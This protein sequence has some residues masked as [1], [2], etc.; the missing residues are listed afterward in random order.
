[1]EDDCVQQSCVGVEC[2]EGQRCA[3]GECFLMQC[4]EQVCAE[5]EVCYQD[6][7][8]GWNC[9]GVECPS[10]HFC[11]DGEC[12]LLECPVECGL[13][14]Q[15]E[16]ATCNGFVFTC[17]YESLTGEP[18]WSDGGDTCFDGDPCTENDSC[19]LGACS[20]TQIVCETPPENHCDG[21]SIVEYDCHGTCQAGDCN[22]TDST[23]DC[24]AGSTC[25][26]DQFAA[27]VPDGAI[28]ISV[29]ADQPNGLK[30]ERIWD[31][32]NVFQINDALPNNPLFKPED[33]FY[34]EVILGVATGG[35]TEICSVE[36]IEG[37][38]HKGGCR[39]FYKFETTF[40]D[41]F[42]EYPPL[43]LDERWY[44]LP[45]NPDPAVVEDGKLVVKR[46]AVISNETV[47]ANYR[48]QASMST[49]IAGPDSLQVGWLMFHHVN[50]AN[51]Y[52]VSLDKDNKLRLGSLEGGTLS[53]DLVVIQTELDY[54]ADNLF[55]ILV[56]DDTIRVTVSGKVDN[57][58]KFWAFEYKPVGGL[59]TGEVKFGI[60]ANGPPPPDPPLDI[61]V[62][63]IVFSDPTQGCEI[64]HEDAS[65]V[66][67]YD[68]FPD[69]CLFSALDY[70]LSLG[71]RPVINIGQTPGELS[72]QPVTD[73][74]F[75]VNTGTPKN[76]T[77]YYNYML[78]LFGYLLTEYAAYGVEDW[79]FRLSFEPD[80]PHAWNAGFEKYR[81]LYDHTMAAMHDAGFSNPILYPGNLEYPL[82]EMLPAG[83]LSGDLWDAENT[84]DLKN[85]IPWTEELAKWL[86]SE[87]VRQTLFSDDFSDGTWTDKW[88]F[89]QYIDPD[90]STVTPSGK[91]RIVLKDPHLQGVVYAGDLGWD[92]YRYSVKMKT[93][94]PGD[95][96]WEVG[97]LTFH[98]QGFDGENAQLFA[99]AL[100]NNADGTLQVSRKKGD[101]WEDL[102]AWIKTG[103]DP[104]EEHQFEIICHAYDEDSYGNTITISIDG[105]TYF[106][107]RW[108]AQADDITSGKV[109]V[110]ASN[111]T[112]EIDDVVVKTLDATHSQTLPRYRGRFHFS[113][114]EGVQLQT[115][116]P[117]MLRGFVAGIREKIEPY[118]PKAILSIDEYGGPP[119]TEPDRKAAWHAAMFT[120]ANERDVR[121]ERFGRWYEAP[122]TATMHTI[123]ACAEM[124]AADILEVEINAGQ[125]Y[126]NAL[127]ARDSED[128][129]HILIFNYDDGT[130]P[131][132]PTS[133]VQVHGLE[134]CRNYSL[135]GT[136]LNQN[137]IEHPQLVASLSSDSNG[138]L[139]IHQIDILHEIDPLLPPNN[140][141]YIKLTPQ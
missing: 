121:L 135:T 104:K 67:Y 6:R 91:F 22:Y 44:Q 99:V 126:V 68:L 117:R 93:V 137:S 141:I 4:G 79:I 42:S 128:D 127:A 58:T 66:P 100:H 87:Q 17:L 53:D 101:A 80:N 27:C 25:E 26:N 108:I 12:V 62:D 129:I 103:L 134:A 71:L 45:D 57:L 97:W 48:I 32:M 75:E 84:K 130:Q 56:Y 23:T 5:N 107:Y 132:L 140:I 11:L 92:D 7:C 78:A 55:E 83:G 125:P 13:D 114:Y 70:V 123:Q 18:A 52:G 33:S 64:Y 133:T 89:Y 40:S 24:P 3:S 115:K 10:G 16:E 20:G 120:I 39:D 15:C 96:S 30:V 138:R 1:M 81:E 69:E 38:D 118:M 86:A 54:S 116:D 110:M 113:L 139:S 65:G 109:G 36:Q 77:K 49:P 76:Y 60:W 136:Y 8:T 37:N 85:W 74:V 122:V 98:S 95:K 119:A 35:K 47:E 2:P 124:Y 102:P 82:E 34:S 51:S 106:R 19:I 21:N 46:N 111:S 88:F 14:N 105:V 72:A 50:A 59:A 94:T 29:Y 31:R 131:N 43:D 9:V 73:S 61:R 41:D 63:N 28:V 90:L 112:V